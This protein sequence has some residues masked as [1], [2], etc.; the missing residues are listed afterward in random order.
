MPSKSQI[1]QAAIEPALVTINIGCEY[2]A[3]SPAEMYRL[4]GLK[5]VEG[6]KAGK[7]TLLRFAQPEGP[8]RFT[9]TRQDQGADYAQ[10]QRRM[11]GWHAL[12]LEKPHRDSPARPSKSLCYWRAAEDF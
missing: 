6:V 4:M 7:R 2:L 1:E 9:A 10:A 11:I 5:K 3:V 12:K 8:R